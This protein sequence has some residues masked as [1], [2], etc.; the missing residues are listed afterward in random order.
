ML[1]LDIKVRNKN[2]ITKKNVVMLFQKKKQTPPIKVQT[3]KL[4]TK[5]DIK[6]IYY[7]E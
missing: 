4:I 3:K 5:L 6:K 1:N 2:L 7:L